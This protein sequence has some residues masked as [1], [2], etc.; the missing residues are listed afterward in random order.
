MERRRGCFICS[1]MI[2]LQ[3]VSGE[4]E[5]W[6][7]QAGEQHGQKPRG[8]SVGSSDRPGKCEDKRPWKLFQDIPFI[9][10]KTRE[11][12]SFTQNP[13]PIA[14]MHKIAPCISQVNLPVIYAFGIYNLRKT[15]KRAN[16]FPLKLTTAYSVVK[17]RLSWKKTYQ[18]KRV[19]Q[20]PVGMDRFVS[21][22]MWIDTYFFTHLN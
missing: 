22:P 4:R 3:V 15:W 16:I 10:G 18:I 6:E 14:F 17:Q 7:G 9:M 5:E 2:I 21:S 8:W 1:W 12:W 20:N 13:I 19:D 11:H